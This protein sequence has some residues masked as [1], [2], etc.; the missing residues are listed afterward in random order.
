MQ[1]GDIETAKMHVNNG[2][3]GNMGDTETVKMDNGV[4]GGEWGTEKQPHFIA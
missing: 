3:Y 4:D 1:H 2:D